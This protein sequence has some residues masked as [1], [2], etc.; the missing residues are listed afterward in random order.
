MIKKAIA[1]LRGYVSISWDPETCEIEH[2]TVD[3]R[4]GWWWSLM[5]P[6][7]R[8]M[9]GRFFWVIGPEYIRELMKEGLSFPCIVQ[10]IKK[11]DP[12]WIFW[13]V[14]QHDFNYDSF[15]DSESYEQVP[16]LQE[17]V[18]MRIEERL[19]KLGYD[20]YDETVKEV[21]KEA[22]EDVNF[23]IFTP[24]YDDFVD[25][26]W[27]LYR[28]DFMKIYEKIHTLNSVDDLNEW[29]AEMTEWWLDE[30]YSKIADAWM[31]AFIDNLAEEAKEKFGCEAK[32]Y[33]DVAECFA[34]GLTKEIVKELKY[35]KSEE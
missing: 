5:G 7:A 6:D 30:D 10:M 34:E 16:E 17:S 24:T 9:A 11:S 20:I 29:F 18:E 35:Q 33:Y 1:D 8:E 14:L 22:I 31:S 28:D 21:I 26:A 12:Y 27:E 25:K 13:S 32:D 23:W 19:E 15:D 4:F 2:F 3:D